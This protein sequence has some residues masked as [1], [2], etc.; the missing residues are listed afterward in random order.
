M[1]LVLAML[2]GMLAGCSGGEGQAPPVS[3]ASPSADS[4]A[5]AA[6]GPAAAPETEG[7]SGLYDGAPVTLTMMVFGQ[8]ANV[9]SV[10][11]LFFK[12]HPEIDAKV[13]IEFLLTENEQ[14]CA[15]QIRL[16]LAANETMPSMVR[17][18]YYQL[19]EFAGAGVLRS[20]A[21]VIEPYK[22]DIIP[23]A[24][25]I[26]GYSGEIYATI[27]EI[28]PKIWYYRTDIFE[29]CGIDPAEVKTTEDFLEAG[30]KI[31]EKYPDKYIE[32]L[33]VPN[34]P[35]DLMMRISGNGASFCD[36]EGNFNLASDPNVRAGFEDLKKLADS[37][38]IAKI[39]E[40]STEAE[41]A[42]TDEIYVSQLTGAWL[43][44]HI[45]DW[46]PDQSGKWSAALW[47]EQWRAGS[48][49]G[50]GIWTVP[51]NAEHQELAAD[52]LAKYAFD[53]PV[54]EDIY[55][56]RGRIPALK[57]V[58]ANPVFT[59]PHPFFG[60]RLVPMTQAALDTFA[61]FPY[62]PTFSTQQNI[63]TQY[64]DDYIA[65]NLTIDEALQGAE[66]DMKNQIGNAWD[67]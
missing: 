27:Y 37:P 41:A 52:F 28:K 39:A 54:Q 15:E 59:A 47:P 25:E 12:R 24:Y 19:P 38:Y 45:I 5:E 9:E 11:E 3:Q 53:M 50:G 57:S 18:Q 2:V 36:A 13:D 20:L 63:I 42:Y 65:G 32:N 60:D 29:E 34:N 40:G 62:T 6:P 44:Q 43:K 64:L 30:R 46:C 16:M 10:N 22:D 55:V 7:G 14:A 49:S 51:S 4:A 67:A 31:Q 21:D 17:L 8:T 61:V 66:A 26:M 33:S 48:E 23:Q 1:A 56:A 58:L 35:Y